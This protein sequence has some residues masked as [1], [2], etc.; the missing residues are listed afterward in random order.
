MSLRFRVRSLAL[1]TWCETS[2]RNRTAKRSDLL[3][4]CNKK[5]P[6]LRANDSV[7]E[8]VLELHSDVYMLGILSTATYTAQKGV[9]VCISTWGRSLIIGKCAED[10][11]KFDQF[12][13]CFFVWITVD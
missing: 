11:H 7:W 4:R 1:G 9:C 5:A 12:G 10:E 13:S 2:G 8:Y 6:C 3:H